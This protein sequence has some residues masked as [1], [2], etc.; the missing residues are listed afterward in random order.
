MKTAAC[1]LCLL[2]GLTAAATQARAADFTV[3]TDSQANG[4]L[5]NA[6]YGAS[7][8]CHGNNLSPRVAWQNAP[9]G[10]KSFV[11]TIFDQDAPTGSGW[12]HWIV[13]DIPANV[14]ELPTGAGSVK[15]NLPAGAKAIRNDAG[16]IEYQGVCPPAGETHHYRI[17]VSALRVDKLDLPDGATPAMVGYLT[18][19]NSLGKA[20]ITAPGSR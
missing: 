18:H 13:G 14:T 8:G 10:T 12:W 6:Q 9:A 7:F 19:I 4:R 2:F 3:T 5:T 16:Q 15:G 17:T 1:T 11:V 20:T